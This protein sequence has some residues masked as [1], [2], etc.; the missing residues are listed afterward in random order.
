MLRAALT[1]LLISTSLLTSC[2]STPPASETLPR[3]QRAMSEPVQ[4]EQHNRDNSALLEQVADAQH[5]DGLTRSDVI[6]AIGKGD[7][8]S[9][10]PTCGEKGFDGEDWYYEVGAAGPTYLKARPV[11]ILGFDR[12]GKVVRTYTMRID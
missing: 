12:F 9:R 7:L 10:H 6:G 2:A 3:L 5:L 4:N 1:S 11:L 8:C